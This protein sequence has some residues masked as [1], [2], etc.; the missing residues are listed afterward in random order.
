MSLT[1][2]A[3][4]AAEPVTTGEAKHYLRVDCTDDDTLIEGLVITARRY[5]ETKTKRQLVTATYRYILDAF[6]NSRVIY[7]P[8]PPLVSVTTLKYYNANG[9]LTTMDST[10][11]IV[12]TDS[13]PG[14]VT[15]NP[16]VLNTW[17]STQTNRPNA[18]QITYVAGY[19]DPQDVPM[20]IKNAMLLYIGHLYENRRGVLTGGS[21]SKLPMGVDA[22]LASSSFGWY[23]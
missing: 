7:L 3:P 23:G 13:E 22:L 2:V 4:P 6:P 1:L 20:N 8:K 19:G 10:H 15:L 5:A 16:G 14:R 12:D 17:P 18:V 21:V 11:Y 9:T